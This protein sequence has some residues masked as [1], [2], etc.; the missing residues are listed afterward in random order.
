MGWLLIVSIAAITSI[1]TMVQ[2]IALTLTTTQSPG[3]QAKLGPQ[4][5]NLFRPR[6]RRRRMER[7]TEKQPITPSAMVRTALISTHHTR[8]E[9][10]AVANC[11][12]PTSSSRHFSPSHIGAH[13]AA[14]YAEAGLTKVMTSDLT[15]FNGEHRR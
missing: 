11:F 7:S 1:M 15:F 10:Q 3:G 2:L 5:T 14:V 13:G 4:R 8:R 6:A 12:R 9:K